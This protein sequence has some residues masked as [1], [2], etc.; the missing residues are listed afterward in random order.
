MERWPVI[1]C[2]V[3]VR[4]EG[5]PDFDKNPD[6]LYCITTL[7]GH[8]RIR[9]APKYRIFEARTVVL[10][11]SQTAYAYGVDRLDKMLDILNCWTAE[12]LESA[13]RKGIQVSIN[14]HFVTFGKKPSGLLLNQVL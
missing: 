11:L 6:G 7:D 14:N 4:S 10:T 9:Y 13:S 3:P 5:D 12:V 2:A 1:A 8:H